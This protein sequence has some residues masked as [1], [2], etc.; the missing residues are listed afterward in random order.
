MVPYLLNLGKIMKRPRLPAIN[1]PHCGEPGK[2]RSSEQTLPT[3]REVTMLCLNTDCAHIWIAEITAARTIAPSLNPRP[4]VHIPGGNQDRRRP[5]PQPGN[6]NQPP[7][8]NDDEVTPADLS[9]RQ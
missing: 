7:P 2:A 3:T 8:A 1:C 9:R 5:R 4:D 6:D